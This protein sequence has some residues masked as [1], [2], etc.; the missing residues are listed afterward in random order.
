MNIFPIADNYC[1][2]LSAQELCNKHSVR[3]P[4]ESA[5]MIAFA[6]PEN[7]TSIPNVR[8]NRHYSHPASIWARKTKEN[9]E[10]LILH[11]LAQCEEYSRRYK[12]RHA[13]QDFIEWSSNQ[14]KFLSFV[15]QGLTPF[16]RCFSSHKESLDQT[17]P[18]TVSAYRKFYW[19]DKKEFAKWPSI[20][21]IPAWWNEVSN[22]FIDKSFVG[23][24]YSRR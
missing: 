11:G 3:M 14:Y 23:G 22:I 16:A 4:I 13:A 24:I 20:K 12:R 15:D 17:E 8:S 19:L 6:F 9:L 1:P 7:E 21:E 10:W 5:G 18:D 2:I